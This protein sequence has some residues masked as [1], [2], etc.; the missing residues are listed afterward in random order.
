[1]WLC[2]VTVVSL[3][4]AHNASSCV[5]I[6]QFC[7]FVFFVSEVWDCT[8]SSCWFLCH[9]TWFVACFKGCKNCLMD[10]LAFALS[11][12]A[13]CLFLCMTHDICFCQCSCSS[14]ALGQV[15]QIKRIFLSSRG[16]PVSQQETWHACINGSTVLAGNWQMNATPWNLWDSAEQL[17]HLKIVSEKDLQIRFGQNVHFVWSKEILV[18]EDSLQGSFRSHLV[19]GRAKKF[20]I[21]QNSMVVHKKVLY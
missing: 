7:I 3:Q 15:G 1:V 2:C 19:F 9:F 14:G 10:L 16:K 6:W 12:C 21:G 8:G 5:A 17:L 18:N 20:W 11:S 13:G 4:T